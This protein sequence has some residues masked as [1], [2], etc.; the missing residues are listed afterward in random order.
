M[1]MASHVATKSGAFIQKGFIS[2]STE[3][4]FC[5]THSTASS[6]TISTTGVC[7]QKHTTPRRHDW[8][9]SEIRTPRTVSGR[10]DD[11][12]FRPERGSSLIGRDFLSFL[13]F[14]SN[15]TEQSMLVESIEKEAIQGPLSTSILGIGNHVNCRSSS[16]SR[17]KDNHQRNMH[18]TRDNQKARSA[19]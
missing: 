15:Q 4:R 7:S 9:Y 17:H 11:T 13:L 8:L 6:T 3:A 19:Q 10:G 12:F 1:I 5:I 14:V 2:G 18:T 16:G